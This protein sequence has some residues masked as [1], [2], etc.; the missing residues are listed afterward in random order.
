LPFRHDNGLVGIVGTKGC[1][2]LAPGQ[3][4]AGHFSLFVSAYCWCRPASGT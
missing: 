2:H 3:I 1:N 4:C